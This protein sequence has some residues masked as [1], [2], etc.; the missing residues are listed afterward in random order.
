MSPARV[1]VAPDKFK[2]TLT[3]RE[4]AR[5]MATGWR[6]GDPR[7][8]VEEVPV[9]DGGEGTLDTLV[10]KLD[11]EKHHARA[12][13][14]LGDP[15]DAEYGLART[16]DGLLAIVEM[17]Q[18]SGLALV[19]Q[20]RRDPLRAS[21]FGTGEVILAACRY[22]PARVV[23]CVGGSATTDGGA[24][25]AQALG[26]RLLDE[27]GED[28]PPGG[29]SLERLSRIDATSLHPSVRRVRVVVATDVDN[30]LTGPDG[31]APVFGP[32]KGA[33]GEDVALL[34]RALGHFAAVIQR[35]LG[36]D[37]RHVEG[38]GAAGGLGAGLMA[39]LGARLR[40][41]FD[42]VAE[43]LNLSVRLH[44]ADVAVTGEGRFDR[45]SAG[46]KAPARVLEMARE[47][48]CRSVLIAGEIDE[49]LTPQA[50][51][52]YSLSARVGREASLARTAEVLEEAAADAA[53]R[54]G[55]E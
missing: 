3:A 48:R 17:A 55:G 24:G 37:V 33:S 54:F 18:A 13:G 51:L 52:V 2:G 16:R 44:R 25:A 30:P 39:F 4:A 45:Q 15:V 42:L 11:G 40:P 35:D 26:I 21:T 7:A 10:A 49:G 31:A 29:E 14:P 41:G 5:A 19:E 32:Q 46:G 23:V 38:G 8:N 47:A 53:A 43:V 22:E 50:D 27:N 36:I 20:D 6:R 34:D 9:A 28:L 12:L 1:V